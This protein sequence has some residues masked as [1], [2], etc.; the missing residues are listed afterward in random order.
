MRK[1]LFHLVFLAGVIGLVSPPANVIP[2]TASLSP[3]PHGPICQAIEGGPCSPEG[4]ERSCVDLY[5]GG[6]GLCI[7]SSGLWDCGTGF[8]PG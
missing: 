4:S 2:A 5:D 3:S 6:P 8:Y 7:C 1:K